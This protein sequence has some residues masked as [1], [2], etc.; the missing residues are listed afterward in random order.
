MIETDWEYGT[1]ARVKLAITNV[2]L[3]KIRMNH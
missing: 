2:F 3:Y 1:I